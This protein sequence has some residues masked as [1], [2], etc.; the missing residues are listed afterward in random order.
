MAVCCKE[1]VHSIAVL[2]LGFATACCGRELQACS[3]ASVAYKAQSAFVSSKEASAR[4]TKPIPD[5]YE[6]QLGAPFLLDLSPE[7]KHVFVIAVT[8]DCSGVF[9]RRTAP[10]FFTCPNLQ[11]ASSSLDHRS[12]NQVPFYMPRSWAASSKAKAWPSDFE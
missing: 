5:V 9:F 12:L 11:R 1:P 3:Q 2:G 7:T 8:E 6:S 4:T 10:I